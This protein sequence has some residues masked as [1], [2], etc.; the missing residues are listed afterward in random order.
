M[1]GFAWYGLKLLVLE[2]ELSG[3]EVV[4]AISHANTCLSK[5][6][7]RLNLWGVLSQPHCIKMENV[8]LKAFSFPLPLSGVYYTLKEC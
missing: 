2:G 1:H 3:G 8:W 4:A 5:L 7:A 6:S